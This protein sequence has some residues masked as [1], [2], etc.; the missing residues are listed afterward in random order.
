[1]DNKPLKNFESI[2]E[3]SIKFH[4][5][6]NILEAQRHYQHCLEIGIEDHRVLSNYAII[7]KNQ[8]NLE[9]AERLLRKAIQMNPNF[10]NAHLNLANTLE[11]LGKY[12]ESVNFLKNAIKLDPHSEIA[13]SN[14]GNVLNN[15]GK[16]KEAEKFLLKAIEIKPNAFNAYNNLG[17]TLQ[18]LG[19]LRKAETYYRKALEI[20]PNSA[21]IHSNLGNILKELKEFNKAEKEYRKAIE[22]DPKLALAYC[23]LGNLLKEI[24]QLDKAESFT[25]KAI[26]ISPYL[27]EAH[28][29]LGFLLGDLGKIN[30]LIFDSKFIIASNSI[31]EGYK[32]IAY[33][34][35]V[36]CN[37]LQKNFVDTSIYLDKA[38]KLIKKGSIDLIKDKKNKRFTWAY[39]EYLS[40]L[41]PLLK[42]DEKKCKKIILHIGE[43]H[44]L[45]FSHQKLFLNSKTCTIQPVLIF[46]AKAW[47]FADRS[48]NRFKES[49][50]KQL[51]N[52]LKSDTVFLSFGEIDCRENEGILP[53]AITNNYDITKICEDTIIGFL[54]YM[55]EKLS[56]KFSN[57]FY[58]GIPAP[59]IKKEIKKD[60]DNI[61][62]NM[63]EKYN[64]LFK[65]EVLLRGAFFLDVYELTAL[66]GVNNQ[67]HMCDDTHLSPK[68]LSILFKNHLYKP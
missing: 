8:G 16:F 27:P 11:V 12:D 34:R 64:A 36:I 58:F 2:I 56:K 67:L 41:Y 25:R 15:L 62:I 26:K 7:L 43:S 21:K 10:A 39:Y 37:I 30:E 50:T 54:D 40:S 18:E 31:D 29:N 5:E 6:G 4:V 59:N 20:N 38:K 33:L 23:N 3:K 46:G 32:L 52:H 48:R 49:L 42:K 22:L 60:I 35:L 24:G 57:R 9:V 66:N 68:S 65:K 53:Y 61:R 13:Y 63:I 47:H 45:S 1:M 19:E 28:L 44:C 14:L 55:E 51:N 17:N